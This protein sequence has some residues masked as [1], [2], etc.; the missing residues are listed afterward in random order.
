VDITN[1]ADLTISFTG[2]EVQSVTLN[3]VSMDVDQTVTIAG[4]DSTLN[5]LQQVTIATGT[6]RIDVAN[7]L[8]V[9]GTVTLTLNGVKDAFGSTLT[10]DITL[11]PSPDGSAVVTT[12]NIDLSGA[13]LTPD[14]L[15]PR[16]A[17]TIG[18]TNVTVTPAAAAD[19]V[20]VDP[21]LEI[22]P[23]EVILS[24]VPNLSVD[25]DE[26]ISISTADIDLS[27]MSDLLGGIDFN[28]VSFTVTLDNG[29]GLD[30]RVDSLRMTLLDSTGNPVVEGTDTARVL[31]SNDTSGAVLIPASTVTTVDGSA[32]RFVNLLLDQIAAGNDVE[33]AAGGHAGPAS[34]TGS[35]ALGDTL[36]VIFQIALAPSLTIDSLGITFDKV[37]ANALDLD[38]IAA[39]FLSD[40]SE[41][42]VSA[43]LEF[44]V[45]N[46]MPLGM[47]VSLALAPTPADTLNFDPFAVSPNI[48]LPEFAFAAG[49]VDST[50]AVTAP[51]TGT[52]TAVVD[53]SEFTVLAERQLGLGLQAAVTGPDGGRALL[54][55]TDSLVL[56]PLLKLEIR[57]AGSAGGNQ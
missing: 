19:A 6:L 52:V 40:L 18:G 38:S 22:Q 48:S 34:D 4:T 29:T 28:D 45:V 24:G 30:M 53:P 1:T 17:G 8:D 7:R 57:V 13:V 56:R 21:Y 9:G 35:V 3:S 16:I 20:T 31:L 51:T 54:E 26:R 32:N 42:V 46:G 49:Q 10:S 43:E 50:G 5:D 37:V 39:E 2:L 41:D 55:P 23:Q 27:E 15:E 47:S 36:T 33:V 12:A 11:Q 14:S 44:D 25:L